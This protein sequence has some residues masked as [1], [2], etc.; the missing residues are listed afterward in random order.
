MAQYAASSLIRASSPH[1]SGRTP[2][3]AAAA[4][5]T[6]SILRQPDLIALI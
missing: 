4:A 6:R 2:V 1:R 3:G 5:T